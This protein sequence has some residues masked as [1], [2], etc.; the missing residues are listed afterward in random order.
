LTG[1]S[2]T[3]ENL[4]AGGITRI[5][6]LTDSDLERRYAGT[7]KIG[8]NCAKVKDHPEPLELFTVFETVNDS[9]EEERRAGGKVYLHCQGGNGRSPTCAMAHLMASGTSK[10]EAERI[11]RNAHRPTWENENID[12]MQ[13]ALVLWEQRLD[14]K[15]M[16][17]F[18]DHQTLGLRPLLEGKGRKV[19]D[20]TEI[21]GDKD[22]S[23]SIEDDVIVEHLKRNPELLLITK[24]TGLAVNC[25]NQK[26]SGQLMYIDE[27]EA[28][29]KEVIHRLGLKKVG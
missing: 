9:I 6:D 20:V 29:A 13:K 14:E 15:T 8:Y 3:W 5:I 23:K 21:S 18:L 12:S 10:Q 25:E 24:D 28:V 7:Y 19:R 16:D 27:S 22:T 1:E 17:L 4:V 2:P 11:V 26:L